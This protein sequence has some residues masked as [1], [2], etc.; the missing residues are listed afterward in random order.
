MVYLVR[1]VDGSFGLWNTFGFD[2]STHVAF[3]ASLVV[4]LGMLFRRWLVP[5]G[6][7]LAAYFVLILVLRYHGPVD[8]L[9]A[10]FV[11]SGATYLAHR[12][13]NRRCIE[14]NGC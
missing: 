10:A 6:V 4:S 5:L 7:S 12:S 1:A 11:A 14:A 9:S 13:L 3:A 2:Y 8:M